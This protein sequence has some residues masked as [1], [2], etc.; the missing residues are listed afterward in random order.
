MLLFACYVTFEDLLGVTKIKILGWAISFL[1]T[2]NLFF[3]LVSAL[4]SLRSKKKGS[5]TKKVQPESKRKKG[6]SKKEKL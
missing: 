1:F 2:V 6:K 5:K 3:E 4:I